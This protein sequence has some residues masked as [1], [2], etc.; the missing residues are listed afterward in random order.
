MGEPGIGK[1]RLLF[2]FR[3][4]VPR[5]KVTILERRSQ[6]YGQDTP[7]LPMID[8]LDRGFRLDKVKAASALHDEAVTGV[9][10]YFL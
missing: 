4:S 3:H 9:R 6:S 1:S 8:A 7:Y 2:E 5:D 10:A